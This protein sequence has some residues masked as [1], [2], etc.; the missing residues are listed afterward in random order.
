LVQGAA[1]TGSSIVTDGWTAGQTGVVKVGDYI[2]VGTELKIVT[3]DANSDGSGNTTISIAPPIRVSP[4]DNAAIVVTNPTVIMCLSD[5]NQAR[6]QVQPTPVYN[7]S[8]AC[9]EPLT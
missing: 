1:Q 2:Q 5:G 4:N 6:W 7:L 8:I 9:E 3:A